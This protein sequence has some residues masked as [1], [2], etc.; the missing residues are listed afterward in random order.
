MTAPQQLGTATCHDELV[1][2]LA[3]RKE[4]LGL[5]NAFVDQRWDYAPGMTDKY[6]GPAREKT[7]GRQSLDD[8]MQ[9]LGVSLV[10]VE[11]VKKIQQEAD[12]WEE[13]K[14]GYAHSPRVSK[15]SIERAKPVIFSQMGTKSGAK[16]NAQLT[17]WCAS[18]IGRKGGRATARKRTKEQRSQAARKAALARWR[19]PKRAIMRTPAHQNGHKS[20]SILVT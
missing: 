18:K 20:R 3:A 7:L 10:I 5:S 16:R 12:G 15:K 14:R 19:K 11:D 4:A 6:L 9:V 13:R 1:D 2:L 8:L 17:V